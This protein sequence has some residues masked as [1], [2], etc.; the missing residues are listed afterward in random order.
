MITFSNIEWYEESNVNNSKTTEIIATMQFAGIHVTGISIV[1]SDDNDFYP[2]L[3]RWMK[4]YVDGDQ[5]GED[6]AL[7]LLSEMTLSA[8]TNNGKIRL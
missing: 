1:A 5:D 2:V 6:E 4:S 3:N 8:L 7:T